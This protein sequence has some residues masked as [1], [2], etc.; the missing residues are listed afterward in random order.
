VSRRTAG[1]GGCYT[2]LRNANN[3]G[4]EDH[5]SAETL[6]AASKQPEAASPVPAATR[7]GASR[8]AATH[9]G[10]HEPYGHGIAH[11]HERTTRK[12]VRMNRFPCRRNRSS[13]VIV[14]GHPCTAA[15]HERQD[16]SYCSLMDW[17][18]E[19]PMTS[20]TISS[21]VSQRRAIVATA[22]SRKA[23]TAWGSSPSSSP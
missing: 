12:L 8:A 15:F 7:P 3:E 23:R 11:D 19:S 13:R 9:D 4:N 6:P 10:R 2:P 20:H 1:I 5:I 14:I 22:S 21:E 16:I 18:S 17:R